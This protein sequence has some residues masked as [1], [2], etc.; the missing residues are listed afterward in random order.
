MLMELWER[1]A[2]MCDDRRRRVMRAE[3][4]RI[5]YNPIDP[6][7]ALLHS[8]LDENAQRACLT[9]NGNLATEM[10]FDVALLDG[11]R[12]LLLDNGEEAFDTHIG[13]TT[14]RKGM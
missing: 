6:R 10:S 14:Q 8:R 3:N 4:V 7:L 11:S 9:Y 5:L 1:V 2:L 13:D 12:R